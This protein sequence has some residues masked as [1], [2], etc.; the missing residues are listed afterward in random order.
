MGGHGGYR[1]GSGRKPGVLGRRTIDAVK[2]MA[3]LGEQTLGVLVEAMQNPKAPWSSRIQARPRSSAI[4]L[5]AER[6]RA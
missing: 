2:S 3:P 6:H 1:P 4:E 5:T